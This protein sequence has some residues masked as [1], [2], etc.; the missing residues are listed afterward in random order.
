ME[1]LDSPI[2]SVQTGMAVSVMPR[3]CS[4]AE[5]EY[6][7]LAGARG[8]S[9]Y[10]S[11]DAH[12]WQPGDHVVIACGALGRRVAALARFREYADDNALFTRQSPWRPFNRRVLDRYPVSL[13]ATFGKT[14]ASV[15]ATI[16]DISAGG[17]AVL[18]DS[19]PD[20][21][22]GPLTITAGSR[23]ITIASAVVGGHAEDAGIVLH[24]RFEDANP[25]AAIFL[26]GLIGD[27]ISGMTFEAA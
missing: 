20:F 9:V 3:A 1:D 17:A 6:G 22:R 23:Q 10:V 21:V 16:T 4:S 14:G 25:D 12:P 27:I 24:L 26:G 15:P 8:F 19:T 13:G 18:L 11:T 5:A 7:V 2:E